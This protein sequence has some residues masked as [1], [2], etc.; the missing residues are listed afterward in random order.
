MEKLEALV[1][2]GIS[3]KEIVNGIQNFFNTSISGTY[4]DSLDELTFLNCKTIGITPNGYMADSMKTL[5]ESVCNLSNFVVW[6]ILLYYL[7][8]SLFGYFL[9]GKIDTPWQIFIRIII[10]GVLINSAF[11]ISYSAI[12]LTE[13][14]TE[15]IVEVCGGNTSLSYI[16][17]KTNVLD[18]AVDEEIE[19]I[20]VM[21]ELLKVTL[22]ISV[23]L[24]NIV[25]GV[26]FIL[27]NFFVIFLPII[28]ALGCSKIT[29]KIL[30]KSIAFFVKLLLYQVF[31]AILLEIV[32][33]FDYMGDKANEVVSI[34]VM[35]IF[36]GT[37]KKICRN[38]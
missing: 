14:F 13:N 9:S 24:L 15:C 10:C 29:E 25:V 4:Y 36:I 6:G 22:Y 11:F 7:F 8:L 35:W 28:I 26:R 34:A 32:I 30:L 17:D 2:I 21:D 5:G 12:Y 3:I 38:Y 31:V 23:F 20:F 27:I 33:K 18:I 37:V 1:A 19:N 16:E